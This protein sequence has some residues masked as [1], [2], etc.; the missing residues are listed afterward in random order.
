MTIPRNLS[1]LAQGADSTGVLGTANG[2]TNLT[3]FTV[4]GIVYASSTS[5]LT[6]NSA[7]TF[8]SGTLTNSQ[9]TTT[10][11]YLLNRNIGTGTGTTSYVVSDNSA[12][13][14]AYSAFGARGAS[15]TTNGM[16]QASSSGL[17][18]A[19]LSNGLNIMTLDAT[20]VKFGVSNTQAMQIGATGGV[21]I[22]NT[23]DPG[24][25]NLSVTGT[26]KATG[27]VLLGT[28]TT[29]LTDYQTGTFTPTASFNG[30][31]TGITYSAQSANYVKIGNLVF[32]NLYLALTSKGSA[33]GNFWIQNLPFTVAGSSQFFGQPYTSN[34]LLTTS[35]A[36]F[37][38]G[39]TIQFFNSIS[40]A[41]A[42]LADTNISNTF[43]VN[44]TFVYSV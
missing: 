39:T 36:M 3:S 38:T 37:A 24:A 30:V 26:A 4:N 42:N 29:A 19:G 12:A 33:T 32:V 5:A 28:S 18:S 7:F 1:F 31:S 41:S 22:G 2:G 43:T 17:F 14:T 27:G 21:S 20:P 34:L 6:T 40:A 10:G 15:Y 35:C 8:S 11:T 25:T 16:L 23:T 9:N 13:F 44:H